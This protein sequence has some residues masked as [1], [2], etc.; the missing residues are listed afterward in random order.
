M[1]N[2][3][4][5]KHK[6]HGGITA[7]EKE[8]MDEHARLWISRAMRTDPIEADKIVP[9]IEGIYAAA[10]WKRPRIVIV[11]SPMVMAFAYG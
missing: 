4:R 3:I 9:A 6:A 1:T 8:L 10:G 5:T 11:P 7:R 2:I